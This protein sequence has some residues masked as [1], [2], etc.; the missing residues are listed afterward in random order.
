MNSQVFALLTQ[1]YFNVV[2]Q[3][4]FLSSQASSPM[5]LKSLIDYDLDTLHQWLLRLEN[6][7]SGHSLMDHSWDRSRSDTWQREVAECWKHIDQANPI[8]VLEAVQLVQ[9]EI[10]GRYASNTSIAVNMRLEHDEYE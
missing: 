1:A 8:L 7:L 10:A 4:N 5:P 9:A 6:A 3:V 2:S